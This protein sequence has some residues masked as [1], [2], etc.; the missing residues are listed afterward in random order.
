MSEADAKKA[1]EETSTPPAPLSD[2]TIHAIITQ[3]EVS[4]RHLFRN[5]R[6]LDLVIPSH[7]IDPSP[8]AQMYHAVLL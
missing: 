6:V 4:A 3:V 5:I 1:V 7:V 2:K 8:C